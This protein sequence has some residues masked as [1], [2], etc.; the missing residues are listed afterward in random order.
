VSLARFAVAALA[1]QVA[2]VCGLQPADGVVV[3]RP[4]HSV[5]VSFAQRHKVLP[6]VK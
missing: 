1:E 3:E 6:S 4:G 5:Q 2:L